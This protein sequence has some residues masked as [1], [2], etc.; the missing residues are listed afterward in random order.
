MGLLWWL[1]SKEFACNA[2]D[3]EMWVQSLGRK[4]SLKEKMAT[5]SSNLAQKVN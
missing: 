3:A 2:G 5:H 4:D 1:R